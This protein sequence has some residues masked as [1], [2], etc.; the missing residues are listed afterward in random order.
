M[1]QLLVRPWPDP[2][3]DEMGHDPRSAYVEQFWLSILGPSAVLLLRRLAR[4]L[5]RSP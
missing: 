3:L 2:V 5:E 1:A 4:G